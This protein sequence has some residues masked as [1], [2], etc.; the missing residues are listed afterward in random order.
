MSPGAWS[1]S[2]SRGEMSG[3]RTEGVLFAERRGKFIEIRKI[4]P[5]VSCGDISPSRGE[6]GD[7][8]LKR[9][10]LSVSSLPDTAGRGT[11]KRWRGALYV[12][13]H[14]FAPYRGTSPTLWTLGGE[15][16]IVSPA[17]VVLLPLE[18]GRCPG[19]GQ[20]GCSSLKGEKS[21]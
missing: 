13:R 4:P 8:V 16:K 2:P 9:S 15:E 11:A 12:R 18:G 10:R 6:K 17:G 7:D 20:R 19:T 1:F 21:L 3:D 5:S 14:P